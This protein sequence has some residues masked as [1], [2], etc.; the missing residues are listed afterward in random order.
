MLTIELSLEEKVE[1]NQMEKA[2]DI[3]ENAE[4]KTGEIGRD[5]NTTVHFPEAYR[6]SG[7]S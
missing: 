2:G 3:W 7:G 1:I 6:D 5:R 4:K